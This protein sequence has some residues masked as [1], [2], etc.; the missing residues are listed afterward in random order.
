VSSEHLRHL[1]LCAVHL[2]GAEQSA[3]RAQEMAERAAAK[4]RFLE[5]ELGSAKTKLT[6]SESRLQQMTA[7]ASLPPQLERVAHAPALLPLPREPEQALARYKVGLRLYQQ[8]RFTEAETEL[9]GAVASDDQDARYH[10]YLG[11][12]RLELGKSKLASESL[13]RGAALERECKPSRVFVTL[14]LEAA[15]KEK[16]AILDRYRR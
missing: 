7:R 13:E 5:E 14:A 6:L 3:K 10:Y 15:T 4:T 8:G 11:L 1:E 16:L 9:L 12:C 2:E